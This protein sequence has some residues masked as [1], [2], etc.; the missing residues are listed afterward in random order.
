MA[1]Q[2]RRG[3]DVRFRDRIVL[4]TGA[5]RGIGKEIALGFAREGADIVIATKSTE[6][7]PRI[8]G[9][10]HET[11]QEV[12]ALGRHALALAVDLRREDQVE[13]AIA[14]TL[15]SFGRV[16]ILVNNAGAVAFGDVAS[17]TAKKFDLV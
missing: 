16:D 11:A 1:A 9:T 3:D 12:E 6:P 14:R 7:D 10:I 2:G 5:S 8:P 4:V 15:E 17:W 13:T